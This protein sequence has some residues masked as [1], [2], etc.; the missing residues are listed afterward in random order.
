M[1]ENEKS[2]KDFDKIKVFSSD[3]EKLKILGELLSNKSSRDIIRLL[4]G[5]EMYTN[6]IATKL[7]IRSNLVIHHLK[8]LEDLGVLEITEKKISKKG[9]KHRHFRMNSYLFLAPNSIQDEKKDRGILK[10]IFK[11]GIKFVAVG[12]AASISFITTQPRKIDVINDVNMPTEFES[13]TTPFSSE[14]TNQTTVTVTSEI[15][16]GDVFSQILIVSVVISLGL[17]LIIFSKKEKRLV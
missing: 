11:E 9:N 7:D 15:T 6:E 1:E 3:D 8:K 5:K 17:F 10:R 2:D 4:I 14:I 16:L 13:G 12:V